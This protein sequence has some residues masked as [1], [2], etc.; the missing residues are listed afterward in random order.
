MNILKQE[1]SK[2]YHS[3]FD[4]NSAPHAFDKAQRT[5]PSVATL[6]LKLFSLPP[7]LSLT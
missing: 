2:Y 3:Q 6:S 5:L 7:S 1:F 4:D